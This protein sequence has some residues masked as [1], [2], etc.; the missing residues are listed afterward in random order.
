MT[1]SV[2]V[3]KADLFNFGINELSVFVVNFH[4][5]HGMSVYVYEVDLFCFMIDYH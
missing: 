4:L 5:R 3:S 2:A 1:G